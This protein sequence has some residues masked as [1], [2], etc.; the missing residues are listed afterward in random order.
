MII[1]VL[2][3]QLLSN[4]HY[5]AKAISLQVYLYLWIKL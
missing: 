4:I 5:E 1:D 3:V 2:I